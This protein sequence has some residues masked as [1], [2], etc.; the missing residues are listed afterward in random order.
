MTPVRF[1]GA[2]TQTNIDCISA[3]I[4]VFGWIGGFSI[5][6]DVVKCEIA[7]PERVLSNLEADPPSSC[8]A[9]GQKIDG[10]VR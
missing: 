8:R 10:N 2:V 3:S 5:I 4:S 9:I 1:T 6:L 7:I